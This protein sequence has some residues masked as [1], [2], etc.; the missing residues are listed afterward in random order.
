[1]PAGTLL[2]KNKS[3]CILK[4]VLPEFLPILM[5]SAWGQTGLVCFS[6]NSVSSPL[7]LSLI[8]WEAQFQGLIRVC[9]C[10]CVIHMI[11]LS[12]F[13][14]QPFFFEWSS[15][16][17]SA[18]WSIEFFCPRLL[19][20]YSRAG[21]F[22]LCTMTFEPD[23]SLFWGTLLYDVAC[24]VVF[25]VYTHLMPVVLSPCFC[26]KQKCFQTLPN[27]LLGTKLWLRTTHVSLLIIYKY[28]KKNNK[29]LKKWKY[30]C[31]LC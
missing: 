11:Y 15:W 29:F 24:S 22:N 9:V 23:S 6:S 10:V 27:V 31:S 4:R 25:L 28:V 5:W 30:V 1:M 13:L 12:I 21:F 26:D 17:L 14:K 16:I 3:Y 2:R 7:S 20:I 19:I 8:F 18:S